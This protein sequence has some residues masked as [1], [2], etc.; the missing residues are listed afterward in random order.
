MN[1]LI[2]QSSRF[3]E[4]PFHVPFSNEIWLFKMLFKYFDTINFW[5][6]LLLA[7]DLVSYSLILAKFSVNFLL[8]ITAYSS[9]SITKKN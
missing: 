1:E 5:N 4:Y 9:E 8:S 2:L 7:T 3:I 6:I